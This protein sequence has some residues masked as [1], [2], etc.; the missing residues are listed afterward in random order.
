[1]AFPAWLAGGPGRVTVSRVLGA[2]V[3]EL[4][5]VLGAACGGVSS[6]SSAIAS[7]CGGGG[8]RLGDEAGGI[9]ESVTVR[10]TSNN[11]PKL[12]AVQFAP[13]PRPSLA[14]IFNF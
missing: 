9:V 13:F 14:C 4:D 10:A 12:D 11:R 7:N 2:I 8:G 6:S 3:E 1:M 5:E